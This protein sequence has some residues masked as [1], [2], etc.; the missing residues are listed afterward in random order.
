M[1]GSHSTPH[2]R[3]PAS[4][5]PI[6]PMPEASVSATSGHIGRKQPGGSGGHGGGS[7]GGG[8]GHGGDAEPSR[9]ELELAKAVAEA[10]K[11]NSDRGLTSAQ[12]DEKRAEVSPARARTRQQQPWSS[13]S[14]ERSLTSHPTPPQPRPRPVRL[15]RAP[16]SA[17]VWRAAGVGKR[18]SFDPLQE[19]QPLE[20]VLC[21]T[22][23][24]IIPISSIVL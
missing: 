7:G 15:Q 4:A 14:S 22:S 6:S 16:G 17:D 3:G 12:V 1:P 2:G 9:K 8:G 18:R 11:T 20:R 23:L 24:G 21:R 19:S 10:K 5:D 13:M